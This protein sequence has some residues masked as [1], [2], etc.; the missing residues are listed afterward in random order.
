MPRASDCA[1]RFVV[2]GGLKLHQTCA[3]SAGSAK[4]GAADRILAGF[5]MAAVM[6]TIA[7]LLAFWPDHG[8]RRQG[9]G[10]G[11]S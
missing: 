11:Q 7:S 9:H 8:K 3:L 1:D 6:V 4:E 2:D 5:R 10:C